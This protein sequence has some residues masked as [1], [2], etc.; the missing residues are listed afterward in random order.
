MSWWKRLTDP[1]PDPVLDRGAA[2]RRMVAD[3]PPVVPAPSPFAD[4]AAAHIRVA[5]LEEDLA[6]LS[7]TLVDA[8]A[9][10]ATAEAAARECETAR[11]VLAETLAQECAAHG[12]TMGNLR[13]KS[14]DLAWEYDYHVRTLAKLAKLTD[15]RD[16]ARVAETMCSV[17]R[18]PRC[19]TD[20]GCLPVGWWCDECTRAY[21]GLAMDYG[22]QTLAG[23]IDALTHEPIDY[24]Q[25]IAEWELALLE[26]TPDDRRA[27]AKCTDRVHTLSARDWCDWCETS[28]VTDGDAD[29]ELIE[30]AERL[31]D[32]VGQRI[33]TGVEL[34]GVPVGTVLLNTEPCGPGVVHALVK[35]GRGWWSCDD[36]RA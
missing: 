15:Q 26:A 31:G 13:R 24:D 17:S 28:A 32:E 1:T 30:K 5:E 21:P 18:C 20:V 4:L 2:Q 25:P 29:D 7:N 19:Q 35:T 10:K 8:F 33:V 9:D 23:R 14:T 12:V 34:D 27:C 16:A 3:A 36:N 22:R 6:A 11:A